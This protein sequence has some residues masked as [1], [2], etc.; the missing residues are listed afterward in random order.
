MAVLN[1]GVQI[2]W[3]NESTGVNGASTFAVV[4]AQTNVAV[5]VA[6]SGATTIKIESAYSPERQPGRNYQPDGDDAHVYCTPQSPV[7]QVQY[8]FAGA[9]KA[10]IELS[11]F[12]PNFIRLVSTNDVTAT[13]AVE[14][15]G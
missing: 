2:V 7:A 12:T 3:D 6:V 4:G 13:A 9:G 1:R 15:V 8:V 5:H 14:V 11:P 10:S